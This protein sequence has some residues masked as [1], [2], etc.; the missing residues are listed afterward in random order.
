MCDDHA[1]PAAGRFA[2]RA[3]EDEAID[4]VTLEPVDEVTVGML[5]D[6]S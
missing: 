3:V 2:P 4:P 6:N 5:M 1:H